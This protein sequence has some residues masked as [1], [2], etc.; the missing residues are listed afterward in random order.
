MDEVTSFP[1]QSDP[2]ETSK[3]EKQHWPSTDLRD[4]GGGDMSWGCSNDFQPVQSEGLWRRIFSNNKTQITNS[5]TFRQ[6]INWSSEYLSGNPQD[7]NYKQS[8]AEHHGNSGSDVVENGMAYSTEETS[9]HLPDCSISLLVSNARVHAD[10]SSPMSCPKSNGGLAEENAVPIALI[11]PKSDDLPAIAELHHEGAENES[12]KSHGSEDN[13]MPFVLEELLM[14][15]YA[16]QNT[17]RQLGNSGYTLCSKETE[18][19]NFAGGACF[20]KVGP[21][22]SSL[23]SRELVVEGGIDDS[24]KESCASIIDEEEDIILNSEEE[25]LLSMTAINTAEQCSGTSGFSVCAQDRNMMEAPAIINIL[26]AIPES[27][28]RASVELVAEDDETSDVNLAE[29]KHREAFIDPCVVNDF[30]DSFATSEFL[31]CSAVAKITEVLVVVKEG[32]SEGPSIHLN[33]VVASSVDGGNT[34]YAM[35]NSV[36]VL[37]IPETNITEALQDGQETLS[38]PRYR[39]SFHCAGIFL[40]P[41]EVRNDETYSRNSNPYSSYDNIVENEEPLGCQRGVTEPEDEMSSDIP[42]LLNEVTGVESCADTTGCSQ[43]IPE[44]NRIQS[45][46]GG[47]RAL[48]E[49]SERSNF[50]LEES[51]LSPEQEINLEIFSLYSRSSSCV[52]EVNMVETLRGGTFSAPGNDNDFNFDEKAS[53][54]YGDN[55]KNNA[56]S[57]ELIP[58]INMTETLDVGKEAP[59]HLEHETSSKF[60]II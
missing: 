28:H 2:A 14:G 3:L 34:E 49:I 50:S 11:R 18:K 57:A 21:E 47:K 7:Q 10:F 56:R 1:S 52:S 20:V 17:E 29:Q 16:V 60:V 12:S 38:N 31:S 19:E 42:I 30:E 6:P 5:S 4:D 53:M 26:S 40:S 45:L 55:Y 44:S 35:S 9:L 24:N 32:L 22:L 13:R 51:L 41:K 8:A 36:S 33:D 46:H 37:V 43:C 23:S 25:A 27:N 54:K 58:E 59:A 48:H 15:P 39:S